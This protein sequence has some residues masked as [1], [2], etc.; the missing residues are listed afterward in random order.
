MQAISALNSFPRPGRFPQGASRRRARKEGQEMNASI[1]NS[2]GTRLRKLTIAGLLGR[3]ASSFRRSLPRP[4]GAIP[5]STHKRPAGAAL[6]PGVAGTAFATSLLRNMAG[7]GTFFAFRKHPVDRRGWRQIFK[8]MGSPAEP[9][10][11]ELS[12][13]PF[14]LLSWD[15]PWG[16]RQGFGYSRRIFASVA[17]GAVGMGLLHILAKPHVLDFGFPTTV[18]FSF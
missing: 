12:E 1:K 15:R 5:F 7:T 18:P 8:T 4:A 14:Q 16:K 11:T 13:P 2:A 9:L 10:G 17:P 3:I 6:G